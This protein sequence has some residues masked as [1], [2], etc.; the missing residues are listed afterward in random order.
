MVLD[1]KYAWFAICKKNVFTHTTGPLMCVSQYENI[2]FVI[3]IPLKFFMRLADKASQIPSDLNLVLLSNIGRCGS[4]LLTQM[5]EDLP[6][7]VAVSGIYINMI[8]LETITI[9]YDF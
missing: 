2:E 5:F 7:T 3:Q 8:C 4:T 1:V 9:Y 6:N